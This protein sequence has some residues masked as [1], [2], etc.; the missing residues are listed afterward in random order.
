LYVGQV[1]EVVL[2]PPAQKSGQTTVYT[3]TPAGSKALTPIARA[4]GFYTGAA[5]GTAKVTVT[6]K[7][8]CAAGAACPAHIVEVGSLTV[9]VWK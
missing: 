9:T 6:Q 7:P 4:P 8:K 5:A 1:I 2:P 3:V